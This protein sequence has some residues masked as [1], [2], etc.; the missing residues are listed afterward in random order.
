MSVSQ[1]DLDAAIKLQQEFMAGK[2]S[3]AVH[4][5]AGP[6]L[7]VDAVMVK[8]EPMP[9]GTPTVRGYDFNDGIDFGAL[10]ATYKY[11]GIQAANLGLAIDEVNRM[12]HPASDLGHMKIMFGT[13]YQFL[14][15]GRFRGDSAT[16][17]LE[18]TNPSNTEIQKSEKGPNVPSGYLTHQT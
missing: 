7:A 12:V 18:T 4:S 1:E 13:A 17:L 8:S 3:T 5:S 14:Y 6:G 15:A 16:S 11:M 9:E 10:L 2:T